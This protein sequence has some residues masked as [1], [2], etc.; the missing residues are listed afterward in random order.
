MPKNFIFFLIIAQAILSLFHWLIFFLLITFFP[1]LAQH[2]LGLLS[3]IS[4]LSLSFLASSVLDYNF[5]GTVLKIAY[6]LSSVW[7][8]FAFY[9]AIFSAVM[10]ILYIGGLFTLTVA[11]W[12]AVSAGLLLVTY[13]LIN[14]RVTRVMNLKIKLPNLPGSW[15]GRTAVMVSDLH[16]GHVLHFGFARKIVKLINQQKPDIVF[17][18]GDFFDGVHTAFNEL[19]EEFKKVNAPLGLYFC[20]GN[21]EM[22]AGYGKCEQAIKNAGIKILEDEKVE[23]DGLQIAG[24]AYKDETD[25]TVAD[26]L[27]D[28]KLDTSKASILLK[29]VPNRLTQASQAGVSLQLSGHSH[30]GQIWPFRYITHKIFKGFDY[31]L[32]HFER[33]QVYTSSGAGTWGPP[34]RVFTKSEIIKIVFE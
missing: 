11:G 1:N 21:H 30:H 32:K 5:D 4:V 24:L 33:M 13:G 14:A 25:A 23:V 2:Q 16:L 3:L 15:A 27:K 28:L 34:L 8:V 22:F 6:L 19:A 12:L 17:I 20:S 10:L 29:H 7:L 18:T 26:R 31:G 9:F